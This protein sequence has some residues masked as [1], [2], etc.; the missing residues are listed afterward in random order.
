[1]LGELI[2]TSE[3]HILTQPLQSFVGVFAARALLVLK[4][5][6]HPLYG[7][8][9]RFLNKGPS[10]NVEK[11]PSYWVDKILLHP[12]DDDDAHYK[13]IEWLL[14]T[15]TEGLQTPKVSTLLPRVRRVCYG[16]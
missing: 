3:E 6:L 4:D 13:E 1:M 9:N 8:L 16:D 7:K 11:L 14:D 10:W 12:P 15:F 5:P 2:D